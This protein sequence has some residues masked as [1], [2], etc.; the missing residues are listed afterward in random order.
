[1]LLLEALTLATICTATYSILTHD[2]DHILVIIC[3]QQTF[4]STLFVQSICV[5]LH[6]YLGQT[7]DRHLQFDSHI[8]A[9]SHS[10]LWHSK[11]LPTTTCTV[12]GVGLVQ[13]YTVA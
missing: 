9:Q 2:S 5:I 13:V 1:M 8:H 11:Q 6:T 12:Q 4:L 7:L 3:S 10:V